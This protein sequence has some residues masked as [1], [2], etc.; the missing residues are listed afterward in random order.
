MA[1]YESK[2]ILDMWASSIFEPSI[3][4]EKAMLG[5][6]NIDLVAEQGFQA[7][8]DLPMALYFEQIHERFPDCK[9]VLTM[10]DDSEVWFQSWNVLAQSIVS[11]TRAGS[12]VVTNVAKYMNY[13][14]WLFA[15][16]NKDDAF[17]TAP[18][19]LPDQDKDR[20]IASYE[21]HN[22]RVRE[23]I[24]SDLLLEYN[25]KE[26]WEPL[27]D[28]LEI[29]HCPTD[30]PFPRTNSATSI[31]AQSVIAFILPLTLVLF[32]IFT[33]CALTF[34][35]VTNKTVLGWMQYQLM[36]WL[37]PRKRTTGSSGTKNNSS[38]SKKSSRRTLSPHKPVKSA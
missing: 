31:K 2:P 38:N 19:P 21:E 32:V 10:R 5:T 14:R 28:F 26:G 34:Q 24:P 13:L 29:A 7:T 8:T 25:V 9:F 22:R 36:A 1:M 15:V 33:G 4:A 27:C 11:P 6:P 35:R 12:T 16:I 20:A 3:A 18:F 23:T 30:T 37:T 17:L